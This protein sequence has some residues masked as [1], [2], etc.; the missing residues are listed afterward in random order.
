VK[1]P[2]RSET[3]E[4]ESER[5][6][7]RRTERAVVRPDEDEVGTS[8]VADGPD[9]ARHE[10]RVRRGGVVESETRVERETGEKR[11]GDLP[12]DDVTCLQ[13]AGGRE[14]NESG[15]RA[16]AERAQRGRT[17]EKTSGRHED[18]LG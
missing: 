8:D 2:E 5:P 12:P 18:V 16:G 1:I 10:K 7:Q 9:D 15:Q 4:G 14:E 3:E 13:R 6:A 17:K 11:R